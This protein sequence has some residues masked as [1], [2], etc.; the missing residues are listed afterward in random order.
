MIQDKQDH[1][2]KFHVH[3]W[4][5]QPGGYG[6]KEQDSEEGRQNGRGPGDDVPQPAGHE[7]QLSCDD[8]S[9]GFR[10]FCSLDLVDE[11]AGNIE[12]TGKP[13]DDEYQVQGFQVGVEF[14]HEVRVA[15]RKSFFLISGSIF[16]LLPSYKYKQ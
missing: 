12:K 8:A 2:S 3:P 6:D 4:L 9:V 11:Q 16:R 13:G 5:L 10:F 1:E 15:F 14:I 7:L